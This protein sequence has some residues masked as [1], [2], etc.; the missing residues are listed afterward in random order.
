MTRSQ[1]RTSLLTSCLALSAMVAIAQTVKVD[2]D[3]EVDFAKFTTYA[4]QEDRSGANPLV[5]KRIVNA[6]DAQLAAK[7]WTRVDAPANALVTYHA[8][9]DGRRQLNAWGRGPR[10]SGM[11]TIT[12][13]MIYTGQIVVDISD[14]A[15]G[16]LIWR[17]VASDTA[18]DKTDKNE[19]RMNEAIAKLFKQFPPAPP[20]RSAE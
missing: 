20:R 5:D 2:Y 18:S 9:I 7:G 11:G 8:A 3:R 13:E 15:S 19:K 1:L 17:G 4:W 14:A 12:E 6:I 16:Q 10:W